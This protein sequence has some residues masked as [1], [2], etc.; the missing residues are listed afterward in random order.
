MA[1]SQDPHRLMQSQPF[2]PGARLAGRERGPSAF[3]RRPPGNELFRAELG[4]GQRSSGELGEDTG[5]GTF[6][7]G[8]SAA[9]VLPLL[10]RL[11]A[12]PGTHPRGWNRDKAAGRAWRSGAGDGLSPGPLLPWGPLNRGPSVETESKARRRRG[13]CVC[14]LTNVC[15]PET[16]HRKPAWVQRTR[17]PGSSPGHP[18]RR[19]AHRGRCAPL[20]ARV[21]PALRRQ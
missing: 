13:V 1:A 14:V 3:P 19:G 11:P 5:R 20:G 8:D 9:L 4:S 12:R 6:G 15:T 17:A 16:R 2:Q 18:P 10:Y 7:S 21:P